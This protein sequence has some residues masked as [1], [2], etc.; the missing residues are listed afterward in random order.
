MADKAH[1]EELEAQAALFALGAMPPEEAARFEQ[2]LTSGCPY[3]RAEVREC[4]I[5]LTALP[6][7]A[8]PV[9]P[10]PSLRARVLE[11]ITRGEEQ[12]GDSQFGNGLV[13]RSDETPWES[14]GVP[15]VETRRL[16]GK[17]TFLVR[18]GPQS[19]L[20]AHDHGV[21]AE[22]CLVLEGSITSAG[23]TA[24]AGDFTYMPKGTHHHPLY[25]EN[26][27]LLLIAYT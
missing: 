7:S 27:C 23:V 22:Q 2:R 14:A 21:A 20:P 4:Q 16:H 25:S 13:V 11:G 5:A 6:L 26:G 8:P 10:P 1:T 24:Y 9:T 18:M 17:R 19:W 15:G 12:A 3:C